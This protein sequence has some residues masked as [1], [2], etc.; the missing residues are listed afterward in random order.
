MDVAHAGDDL[1]LGLGVEREGEGAVLLGQALQAGGDFFLVALGERLDAHG[2]GGGGEVDAGQPDVF[3]G[4]AQRIARGGAAELGDKA[5][6]ARA[7]GGGLGLLVAP[8]KEEQMCIRDRALTATSLKLTAAVVF[9][10]MAWLSILENSARDT[11]LSGW[12]VP[13]V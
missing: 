1:L 2:V 4:G 11:V 6:V 8:D 5:D 3:A 13:S 9:M 7:D 10:P 12:K